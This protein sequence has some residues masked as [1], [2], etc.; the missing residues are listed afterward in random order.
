MANLKLIQTTK[1]S[2]VENVPF[3]N[4]YATKVPYNGTKSNPTN[5]SD[6]KNINKSRSLSI[7][8]TRSLSL[9]PNPNIG[10]ADGQFAE[11]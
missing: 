7:A 6:T 9:A 3:L 11:E 4:G 2:I 8:P 10:L 1:N 5:I